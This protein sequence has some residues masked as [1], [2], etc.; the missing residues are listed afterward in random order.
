MDEGLALR[1]RRREDVLNRVRRILI[2]RLHV[3]RGPDELDPETPLFGTGL[4]LDSVDAVELLV[5]VGKEFQL[6]FAQ[7]AF[8]KM[9]LRTVGTVVDLVLARQAA[10]PA[11]AVAQ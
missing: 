2:E 1:I 6:S 3:D 10:A 7:D 9:H 5:S 4:G 8:G 11:P